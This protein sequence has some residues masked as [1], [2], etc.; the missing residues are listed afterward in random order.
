[1]GVH[2]RSLAT[3]FPLQIELV[4]TFETRRETTRVSFLRCPFVS[5][6]PR[7]IRQLPPGRNADGRD[8]HPTQSTRPSRGESAGCS[9]ARQMIAR[10]AAARRGCLTSSYS[11]RDHLKSERGS[12]VGFT[13]SGGHRVV[14]PAAPISGSPLSV[15]S[16]RIRG[17]ILAAREPRAAK[18]V[19]TW[20]VKSSSSGQGLGR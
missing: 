19:R 5:A 13:R 18:E 15:D 6:T 10:A 11:L 8:E 2:A 17:G 12:D 20:T 9:G 14:R 16:A 3:Q 7:P 1:M 4:G